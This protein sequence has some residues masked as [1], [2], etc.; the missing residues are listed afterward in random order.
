MSLVSNPHRHLISE[1]RKAH[2]LAMASS[3]HPSAC[4][5]PIDGSQAPSG[6]GVGA[7]SWQVDDAGPRIGMIRQPREVNGGLSGRRCF[8]GAMVKV[9][10]VA[11]RSRGVAGVVFGQKARSEMLRLC[12]L[13]TARRAS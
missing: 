13:V 8:F 12:P 2:R 11:S 1:K 3:S 10:T 7:V 4:L 9:P 6:R 5:I